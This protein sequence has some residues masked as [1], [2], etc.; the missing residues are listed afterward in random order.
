MIPGIYNIYTLKNSFYV[1]SVSAFIFF[2]SD[3]KPI[4]S[5]MIQHD[6]S[7]ITIPIACLNI[8]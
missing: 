8:F 5:L 3:V 4:R 6:T 7:R 2:I 1:V